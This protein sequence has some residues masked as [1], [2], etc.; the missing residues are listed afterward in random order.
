MCHIE[1][2]DENFEGGKVSLAETVFKEH[3]SDYL[4]QN[5]EFDTINDKIK[6]EGVSA[7]PC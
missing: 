7:K 3:T 4:K 6:I 1:T 5:P 2:F